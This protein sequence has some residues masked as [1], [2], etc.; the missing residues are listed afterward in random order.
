MVLTDFSQ[1]FDNLGKSLSILNQQT[2]T[3]NYIAKQYLN[4]QTEQTN[5]SNQ[6]NGIQNQVNTITRDITGDEN[7]IAMFTAGDDPI[8]DS[9]IYM[10]NGNVGILTNNPRWGLEIDSSV[11]V[12]DLI[13]E[14]AIR[15]TSG[16]IILGYGS[17]LQIGSST[18]Y[19]AVNI[20]TGNANPVISIDTSGLI[21]CGSINVSNLTVNGSFNSLDSNNKLNAIK[22]TYVSNASLSNNF[23]W[24]YGSLYVNVSTGGVTGYSTAYID[25]SMMA[26]DIS[27]NYLATHL[28][29]V[30]QAYVDGALNTVKAIYIPSAS[31]GANLYWSGGLL[32]ASATGGS[33]VLQTYVDG[34]LLLR[35]A[36]INWLT[37]NKANLVTPGFQGAPT[38]TTANSWI[39][40]TQIAT[41][42]FV[43]S[44]VDVSVAFLDSQRKIDEAAIVSLATFM[45]SLNSSPTFTGSVT[46]TNF[47]LSSDKKLKTNITNIAKSAPDIKYKQFELISELGQ[48]RY[49]VVAQDLQKTHPE[50]IRVNTAG[51]L[52]V[53]YIDLLILEIHNL[54]ERV[55]ELENKLK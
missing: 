6:V 17:P 37:N 3:I 19:R 25:G 55:K 28:S 18:N 13:I 32:N 43:H 7:T 44:L 54:K 52:N 51:V 12:M 36:S 30:S 1:V 24:S 48:L 34:S 5:I 35:D 29:G 9:S 8:G 21:T 26:R 22:A 38:S 33:G 23:I 11:K 4:I 39:N 42:Q 40:N 20:Y 46:A 53:A 45:V 47:I 10:K 2:G 50:L 14:N 31:I 15:D 16:N 41:T 27:I 49:G